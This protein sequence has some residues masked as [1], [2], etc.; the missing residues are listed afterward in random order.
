M[1]QVSCY[2]Y[3]DGVEP[4]LVRLKAAGYELHAMSN[5]PMW[6]RYIE[7][8]LE[9][10]R[11]L[12]WTFVSCDGPMQVGGQRGEWEGKGGEGRGWGA[13]TLIGGGLEAGPRWHQRRRQRA[14]SVEAAIA[15]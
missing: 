7:E 15:L 5:Y 9:L 2:R 10:S 4:L 13:G 1:P 8:R 6:F 14:S 3:L 12:S 11:Y